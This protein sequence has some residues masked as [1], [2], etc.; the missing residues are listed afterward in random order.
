MNNE[1]RKMLVAFARSAVTDPGEREAALAALAPRRDER[2][3]KFLKTKEA[4]QL[5]AVT[6]KTLRRWEKS[7]KLHPRHLTPRIVR[8]SRNELEAFLFGDAAAEA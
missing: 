4:M 1:T 6:W 8:W 2:P 5:A 3:D 7:G